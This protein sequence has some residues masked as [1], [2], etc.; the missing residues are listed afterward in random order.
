MNSGKIL[1]GLINYM[2]DDKG[3]LDMTLY[4]GI[5]TKHMGLEL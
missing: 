5:T 2:V 4:M 3:F 1:T